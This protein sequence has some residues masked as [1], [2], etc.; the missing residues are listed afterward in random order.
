MTGAGIDADVGRIVGAGPSGGFIVVGAGARCRLGF[1]VEGAPCGFGFES[2]GAVDVEFCGPL[3]VEVGGG[4]E[5]EFGGGVDLVFGGGIELA[6][7][8]AGLVG[9][10]GAADGNARSRS[11]TCVLNGPSPEDKP[12]AVYGFRRGVWLVR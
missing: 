10:G 12:L 6:G 9:L 1:E 11:G 5:F 8:A 4:I 7:A 3:E 2:A